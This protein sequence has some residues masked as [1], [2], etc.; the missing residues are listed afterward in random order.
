MKSH[1]KT[2]KTEESRIRNNS[3]KKHNVQQ[4]N[5]E[6]KS[7][8][9]FPVSCAHLKLAVLCHCALVMMLTLNV[10]LTTYF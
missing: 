10:P 1:F 3:K 4:A 2:K 6:R 8:S 5:Y 7:N 9:E